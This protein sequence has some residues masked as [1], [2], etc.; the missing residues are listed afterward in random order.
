MSERIASAP[1]EMAGRVEHVGRYV[2]Y[3]QGV[4]LSEDEASAFRVEVVW[5]GEWAGRSGG[6]WSVSRGSRDLLCSSVESVPTWETPERF[7]RWQFRFPSFDA[8][9]A[10]ARVVV[11]GVRVNGRTWAQ[12]QERAVS[13]Q[14]ERAL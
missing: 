9:L 2:L 8:A 1:Q 14:T 3:P 13:E 5:R 12:W 10:A 6:G 11:D 7:R 4:A